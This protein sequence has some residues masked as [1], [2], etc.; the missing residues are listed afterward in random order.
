SIGTDRHRLDSFTAGLVQRFHEIDDPP[1]RFDAY[2]K[3]DG[4][5][6]LPIDGCWARAPY[7]HNGAV[8]TLWDL[9]QPEERRAKVFYRGYNVYDPVKLGYVSDGPDAIRAGFRYDTSV[10]GNGNAGH[11]YGT[12]L[13][14]ADKWDLIEYLKT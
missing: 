8:P 7:L 10:E 12:G 6:N 1:F 4:Y 11:A 2:R 3:T 5:S 9:L 13:G 14:D